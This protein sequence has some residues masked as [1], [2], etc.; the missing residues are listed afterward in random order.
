VKS[1]KQIDENKNHPSFPFMDFFRRNRKKIPKV[2]SFLLVAFFFVLLLVVPNCAHAEVNPVLW[3]IKKLLGA[4][5]SLVGWLLIIPGIMLDV[6]LKVENNVL[7]LDSTAVREVW[8]MVRDF[9]NLFFILTLLFSAFATIFQI[10]KYHIKKIIFKIIIMALLVNFSF[11]IARFF[12]DVSNVA[13]YWMLNNMF[14]GSGGG[15]ITVTLAASSGLKDL[16]T[17]ANATDYDIAYLIAAI[18]FTFIFG[19]TLMMIAILF[20]VRLIALSVVVMFSPIGFVGYVF[21]DTAKYASQWW[22][23]LLKYSFFAPVMTFGLAVTL[24]M[25]QSLGANSASMSSFR[26][27]AENNS[28]NV[29]ADANWIAAAAFFVVPIVILWLFMGV[30]Q[31]FSIAGASAV[32]KKGQ[33]LAKWAGRQPWRGTKG[34]A[35]AT[36]IPGG[37]KAG[38]SKFKKNGKLFGVKV[39]M[40]GGSDAREAREAKYAGFVAGGNTGWKSAAER[41]KSK[42][43]SDKV[44][45]YKKLNL[46]ENQMEKDL[47]EGDEIT[48]AAAAIHM[49][50]K[51]QLNNKERISAAFKATGDNVEARKKVLDKIDDIGKNIQ[52][53]DEYKEVLESLTNGLSATDQTKLTKM[54]E[55]KIKKDGKIEHLIQYDVDHNNPTGKTRLELIQDRLGSLSAEDLGKQDI[56]NNIDTDIDLR[57]YMEDMRTDDPKAYQEAWGKMRGGHRAKYIGRG[58]AP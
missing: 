58:M 5:L 24:K 34:L 15:S 45:E 43:I 37:V 39:P 42:Q 35:N 18:I 50:E 38:V 41:H 32:Q 30:A 55:G 51:G 28:A 9:L 7:Y 36:G 14:G 3:A 21:P 47:K 44:D 20:L 12:I 8:V 22:D 46:G 33:D 25:M 40:Y 16:L 23:T 27:A 26:T 31:K 4:L 49:S 10:E 17:P 56:H 57:T 11:P 2:A 52:N 1:Y 13:M 6:L 29:G 48:K 19:I 53:G 54:L